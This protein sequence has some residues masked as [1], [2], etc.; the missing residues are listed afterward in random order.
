MLTVKGQER[1]LEE[2]GECEPIKKIGTIPN[3]PTKTTNPISEVDRLDRL[4][5]RL[6]WLWPASKLAWSAVK[7]A[8][9]TQGGTG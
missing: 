2:E 7:A 9:P 5:W 3:N 8:W 1:R 4:I 6:G